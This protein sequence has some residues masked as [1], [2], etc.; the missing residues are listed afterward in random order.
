MI[1]DHVLILNPDMAQID[2]SARIDSFTKIEGGMGCTIGAGVHVS[3]FCHV[4]IGGGTVIL[5]DGVG[6]GSGAKVLGG[7]NTE[8]GE[9][10]SVA[11]PPDLQVIHRKCTVIRRNAFLS[12]N[13]VVLPGV[14]VGEGAIL[15]AGGVATRDIPAGEVWGGVPARYIRQRHPTDEEQWIGLLV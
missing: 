7:S 11:G 6:L 12:T 1:F 10:M 15:A 9:C 3:S 2:D 4:N 13:S 5:E 14:T 8:Y